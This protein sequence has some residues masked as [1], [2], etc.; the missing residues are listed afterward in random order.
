MI[1]Y[2][3]K[4]VKMIK[5][6]RAAYYLFHDSDRYHIE[7]SLLIYRGNQWTG[8]YMITT[9]V[10]KGLTN[11]QELMSGISI[12]VSFEEAFLKIVKKAI[13]LIF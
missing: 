4:Q 10:M 13:L 12:S 2:F 1:L 6:I 7:T 11:Y 5:N 9:S 8:F 3:N